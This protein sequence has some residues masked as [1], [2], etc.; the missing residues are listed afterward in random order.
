[1]S[2]I[3][4]QDV[5]NRFATLCTYASTRGLDVTW[6]RLDH[7]SVTYGRAFRVYVLSPDHGGHGVHPLVGC[8]GW[9]GNNRREAYLTL[10]GM[11]DVLRFLPSA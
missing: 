3:T 8:D 6:W 5:S 11:I 10:S 9:I 7:G 4:A 2:T 1:M